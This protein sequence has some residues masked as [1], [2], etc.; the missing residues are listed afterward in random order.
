MYKSEKSQKG[1]Q[2]YASQKKK[3]TN[4]GARKK[5]NL[6]SGI[7]QYLKSYGLPTIANPELAS[8]ASSGTLIKA[9][10]SRINGDLKRN[11]KFF[12]DLEGVKF[13]LEKLRDN[14]VKKKLFSS[15]HNEQQ[16][17]IKLLSKNLADF[18]TNIPLKED[19]KS[20]LTHKKNFIEDFQKNMEER[21]EGLNVQS[22][23]RKNAAD[24]I[25]PNFKTL[26][27]KDL[28]SFE[29]IYSLENGYKK[30][31]EALRTGSEPELNSTKIIDEITT[32]HGDKSFKGRKDLE[33][34]IKTMSNKLSLNEIRSICENIYVHQ[35][36]NN[37]ASGSHTS[38]IYRGQGITS[39]GIQEL[40]QSVGKA[41]SPN[42][43]FSCS[44]N[45]E[46]AQDFANKSRKKNE[47][48]LFITISSRTGK[49]IRHDLGP[50]GEHEVMLTPDSR[51]R[52]IAIKKGTSAW[53]LELKELINN[54]GKGKL[55][56]F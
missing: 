2:E 16:E 18:E 52:V 15:K 38:K 50:G 51:L 53:E 10:L 46:V 48:P 24:E 35:A 36:H 9:L 29:L 49:A 6:P 22:V 13:N 7:N 47:I 40:Q 21:Q 42:G 32:M 34:R 30:I 26:P 33:N 55:M 31:N 14:P 11:D 19:E 8:V 17:Q 56:P 43:M 4:L 45:L 27:E 44:E 39:E 37:I 1:Y 12:T 41:I 5:S 28:T 20:D 25:F 23:E 54:K 3:E